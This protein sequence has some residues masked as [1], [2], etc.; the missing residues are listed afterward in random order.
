MATA[1]S[2]SLHDKASASSLL[3]QLK[4]KTLLRMRKS[5]LFHGGVKSAAVSGGVGSVLT[6]VVMSLTVSRRVL[7]SLMES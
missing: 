4:I 5:H 7:R 1:L 3:Q 2:L 6:H